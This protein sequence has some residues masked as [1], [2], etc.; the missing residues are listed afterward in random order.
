MR[1]YWIDTGVL[2]QSR[3]RYH[4]RERVPKFWSWID[5]EL[6]AGR[7]RMPKVVYGEVIKG[8]DWLVQWTKDRQN[9]GLCVAPDRA[10]HQQYTRV[11][12]HVELNYRDGHQKDRSLHGADLWV[13]AHALASQ[14]AVVVSE[15]DK[16]KPGDNRVKVPNVC[17]ELNVKCYDTFKMLDELRA[18]F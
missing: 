4:P 18:A 3:H 6:D 13:I 5:E 16:A 11:A 17:R 15:E 7:L 2:I 14:D 9:R 1:V 12:D 10:V 8:K